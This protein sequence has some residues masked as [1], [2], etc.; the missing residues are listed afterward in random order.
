MTQVLATVTG[1]PYSLVIRATAL[2]NKGEG[3]MK[4]IEITVTGFDFRT[5]EYT[6]TTETVEVA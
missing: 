3:A 1:Y 2:I 5:G 4:T 6:T